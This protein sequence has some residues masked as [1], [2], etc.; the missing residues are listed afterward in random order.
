VM[1][2]MLLVLLTGFVW[3]DVVAALLVAVLI[4]RAAWGILKQTGS[5]LVDTAPY[6]PEH[7]TTLLSQMPQSFAVVRARS[8][9]SLDA[10][11]VDIDVRV[12]PEMTAEQSGHIAT[13]IRERLHAELDDLSEIEIHFVPD[14]LRA[15]DPALT[16]R[17]L[18]DVRGLSTHEV[19]ISHDELG[20]VLELHVEVPPQQTLA[21]AHQQVTQ[22]EQEL[23]QAL[24]QVD[25]IL[26]HIEPAQP[27]ISGARDEVVS[28][29]IHVLVERAGSLLN[30]QFP[31]VGWHEI[32]VR[33]NH[34][35]FAL[36]LHA[37]LP[38]QISLEA[39]HDLS[40]SAE[41]LL[42]AEL[43]ALV[44]VTIHTEP[45]EQP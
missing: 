22:L 27:E 12:A 35:G 7:L 16:A 20:A 38:P 39:A 14:A 37:A 9:G 28:H 1:T 2:S 44:R 10:A 8:R 26:T 30:E 17:A 45:D 32:S 4:G 29:Q 36:S 21:Q 3:I 19:Q 18:A 41:T 33:S 23:A 24:P 43:P 6:S 42:R 34:H 40:E 15:A 13:A 5:V 31:G 25:R 11:H